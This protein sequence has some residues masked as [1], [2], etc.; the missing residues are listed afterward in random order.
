MST[1]IDQ[2]VVEMRFDNKHFENNVQTSLNTLDKLKQ[3]LNLSG[4]SKGLDE[5]NAAAS[6][7]DMSGLSGAI[8]TVQT[9]FSSLEVMAVTALANI[10]NSAVNAGKRIVS[11]LAIEPI[12]TGFSEYETKINAVQTI[13][14]NTASKGTTMDDVTKT[15]NELNTYADKTIYNFAEMT[16]NIGTFTAAGVGLE[17]SASAIQGISNLAAA[18][19]STSQQASTAMYQLS[20]ALASGTVKLMDWNS[21][22]NAGMGGEKFQEALKATARESGIAVDKIVEDAGSFRDSLK[23][24]WLSADILNTTLQKFTVEGA[25]DYAD[26]MV[27]SGKY[28]KEQAEALI[29]EAQAM[30]DAATKVKTFTQLWD[31]LKEAAQSGWAQTWEILVGDFEEAKEFFTDLY[32]TISPVIEASAKARNELLQGWKD[33]GGREH[34]VESLRNIFEAISSIVTPIKQ[35]FDEIFPPTTVD[36]LLGF[37]EGLK[38]F[39]EKLKL[40]GETSENLKQTFAGLFS[41]LDIVRQVF[42]GVFK[43]VS[44]LFGG[45]GSLGSTIL[46][47]TASWGEWMQGVNETIKQ[48]GVLNTFFQGVANAIKA[49]IDGIKV[50]AGFIKDVF[51]VPGLEV[52]SD[53]LD[54]VQTRMLMVK[55]SATDM[56]GGVIS[57]I[58]VM[59]QALANSN[60]FKAMQAL[61]DG[62]KTIGTGITNALGS[63]MGGAIEGIGNANFSNIL[64]I[65]NTAAF[66]GIAVGITKFLDSLSEPIEGVKGILEGVSGILDG[67]KGSLEAW[68]TSI[69]ADTLMKIAK[70]LAILTAAILVISLIDSDKLAASLGVVTALFAELLGSMGIFGKISGSFTGVTKA[71]GAMISMSVAILILAGALK[72]ISGLSLEEMGTGL[73]GILGITTILVGAAK[74]LGSGKST[75]VK[76]ATQMVI[77]AA[78][79]K[80]LA[81]V[82]KDL[83]TLSWEELGKGLVG[84]G[85]L[86]GAV[87]LF[88]NNT[89]M[90]GKSI[91]TATGIVIL[92]SA[93]KILAS[94]CADFASMSWE[95]IGKGLAGISA[96]LLA[97]AGFTKLTGNAKKLVSTGVAMV[98]IAGAMKIFA[99]AMND[100]SAMSWEELAK[101]LTG[102]AG[103]L[104]A[105]VLALN[106]LPKNTMSMG[107]GLIA[108]SAALVI[109]SEALS[110][111]S[112]M[113]WDS[114]ARGLV[115]LG[116]S[117]AILAIGLNVMKGTLSGSAAM[118]VA[119]TAVTILASA[120]GKLGDMSW[121]GIAKS[122]LTLAGA[123]V[124]IGVA[125]A[126]LQPLV[127]AILGLCG[128]FALIGVAILGIGAGLTLAA[129]GLSALAIG[130]TA[131]ATSLAGGATAIVASLTVIIT[132]LASLIP[133][134]AEKIG[135][136]ILTICWVIADGAPAIGEAVK[137][138]VLTLVDVFVECVPAI[139]DGLLSLVS[140]VL[141]SLVEYTPQIVDSIFKFLIGVL[142]GVAANLPALIQSA[143]NVLMSFFS[144][145]A[146]ALSSIDPNILLKGI[147]GVGLL[148]GIMTALSGVAAL[149]P[150]AM[151]G[152]LGIG[153]V[154]AELALVLAAVGALAQIPGLDWL[155]NEGGKFLEGIGVAIGSFVGGIVGGFLGGVTSQFPKIG[156]D[157]SNFMTNAK[158]F[159]EGAKSIDSSVING[160][161]A[162]A[163]MILVLTG[164]SLLEGLTSWITGGSS[165][166]KF[167][168]DI[169]P[170]GVGLKAFS[171]EVSGVKPE[172]IS[173]AAEAAKNLANMTSVIPNEGGVVSWFTGENSIS[174]FAGELGSLGKGL[175]AFSDEVAG[176]NP[177][178]ITSA[179]EAAKSLAEMTAVIP[180][181]GGVASWFAGE[182]SI[183][184]FG[185]EL[186]GLGAGLKAFSD[187]VVGVK[188]E[189]ITSAAEAAKSL[190]DM[191]AIIPDEGGVVSWFA[192]DNSISKF[193]E[194]LT[195]L[196]SGLKSFSKSVEGV[197]PET[198][199][200]AATAAKSLADMT[201]VIPDEGGVVSWF[202]GDNSI[203][204]FAGELGPLGAGLKAF[205]DN[206]D[207]VNP[208]TVTA[209]AT[210]AKTLADMASVIPNEGGVA[211]WFA[212]ENSIAS[213]AGDLGPLGAGIKAFSDATS[214]VEPE[215]VTAAA[216]AA[217][218]LAD[219]T[220]VIPNEGGVASWFAG[221]Q[222]ISKFSEDLVSLGAGIKGFSDEVVGV[223]PATVTAAATAATTLANMTSVI[224]NSGGVASW[225]AGEQSISKFGSELTALGKG[226][227]GFS[228]EVSGVKPETVTAAAGAATTLADMTASTP[229]YTDKIVRF[230]EHI[231]TFGGY[232][233]AYY[234]EV[235]GITTGSIAT[236]RSATSAIVGFA[237][238]IDPSQVNSATT[239][240]E[241]LV[242]LARNMSGIDANAT[243]GFVTAMNKLADVNIDSFVK[244]FKSASSDVTKVASTL[245]D[246]L[247]KG[248]ESKQSMVVKSAQTTVLK[249]ID[250][251]ESRES[252][253]K[254]AALAM[255]SKLID[256][257]KSC[258]SKAKTAAARI[259]DACASALRSKYSGF[260][261]AGKYLVQGFANGISAN[262]FAARAKAAAMAQ[263]ALIA[264]RLALGICSPSKEGYS[265]GRYFDL[266][267]INGMD[268]Y[269]SKVYDTAYGMADSARAGLTNAISRVKEI[270]DSGIDDQ[271]TIRP[272]ID[273]SAV[274]SG[275]G[276][277]N[278]MLGHLTPSVGMLSNVGSINSMMNT[279]QNGYNDDVVSAIKELG[280]KLDN[281]SGNSYNVNGIIYD[282]GS[283]VSNAI[284]T[285]VRAAKV[286]GRT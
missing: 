97:I 176:V 160:V 204:K 132:G 239:A 123:F 133:T 110:K 159:I 17:E 175:K 37:T 190:V 200:A 106:F 170:L 33:D 19:G 27:K 238:R 245:I 162:L 208:E 9:K 20:Q 197:A 143:V 177:E 247:T 194:D 65:F 42:V 182:N 275:V 234:N 172:T 45:M 270:V 113:S 218:T 68:Q 150:A 51:I 58:K 256:G 272:V 76:G 92:A 24:G 31:T 198:I 154:I 136:A 30:E 158:P 3:S 10:T 73:V 50:F 120:L 227:K 59:G 152:V 278:G 281:S 57:A 263:S 32:E 254:S 2:R 148:A 192:G 210:A 187:E 240:V 205:S 39:T 112:I 22:V 207:G 249:F 29:V 109:M 5:V 220:A 40:S 18:S 84:V 130:V 88:L 142:D 94:A 26:A 141:K 165:I 169:V 63:L 252:R 163:E 248:I 70:A 250:G 277:M 212:G 264:A 138:I 34:I 266:G 151:A 224:P 14:S 166:A 7:C 221:E 131:L 262:T 253:V 83:S 260:Y 64:D 201:S 93:M 178:T 35:A 91:T 271:L 122:L 100:M 16:R 48:T 25:K 134:I 139:A 276:T 49:V 11:A 124:I 99:S 53:L 28:T 156:T 191:T 161:N 144:G 189:T 140:E 107:V 193:S 137:G 257:I 236:S 233:S 242:N 186:G 171:D 184:K 80:I 279:R 280:N 118:I 237:E 62:I 105:V 261:T 202:A 146:G 72:T 85:V 12:T 47:L 167:A 286:E 255:I 216:T 222:S 66:G 6:R 4:M 149:T 95:G 104:L 213:F 43:A 101:G 44:P 246:N 223:D 111:M 121:E 128:A 274:K 282:D 230:G 251:L 147:V 228:D 180:N 273:L 217:K 79:L 86:M 81:S 284:R 89:K 61:W 78:A 102:M 125:G 82:C 283:N 229:E 96:L 74:V 235:T 90:S 285:L 173:A 55:K 209:A 126:V 219:M 206:V 226:I 181:E 199:T 119:A 117:M 67:V 41:V 87:A 129:V 54:R 269:S 115:A 244:S 23:N 188:P 268:A 157:L 196:G 195:N 211:S 15:L 75:I 8:Q 265:I 60:F 215:T 214:G 241:K 155:I 267:F 127:P 36:Q 77:F 71:C 174:K 145:I 203:S 38:N 108:V 114:I 21:V 168:E 259:A 69:K 46:K 185:D 183:A 225:F 232:L 1:T 135:E 52:F 153:A 103:A 116:G 98:A 179:A 56:G 13:M 164:A 243:S 258:E 231:A